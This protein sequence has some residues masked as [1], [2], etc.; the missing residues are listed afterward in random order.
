[1]MLARLAW[2]N[3]YRNKRRSLLT[4]AAVSF[5]TFLTVVFRGIAV[6]TWEYSLQ[7]T[8]TLFSGFLQVQ[9]HGYQDAPSLNKSFQYPEKVVLALESCPGVTGYAPRIMADG[10]ITYGANSSG[11]AI[12][13][14]DPLAER[15]VSRF[16]ERVRDGRMLQPDSPDEIV[17]GY[18]L[19][20]NLKA[21]VGD[22]LVVLA[23]GYDGVMGNNRYRVVG[24]LKMGVPEFDAMTVVMN[25]GAVQQLLAMDGR[26]NVVAV[27]S[28]D[29]SGLSGVQKQLARALAQRGLTNVE[30]LTWDEVMPELK[31]AMEVDL[32]NDSV[33]LVILIVIVTFGI[34]NTV[35]MSITERYR[36]FGITL[37]MG[38]QPAVLVRLVLFETALI[39][40]LGI[41]SGGL[42]GH[43][44]NWHFTAHPITLG[45]QLAQFYEDY[46]FLP[47]IVSTT[48]VSIPLTVMGGI[49][50]VSLIAGVYPAFRVSRLEPL[51][52]IRYT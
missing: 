48:R 27:G 7:N 2:R 52:G 24:T 10:L 41:L 30:V 5:A 11:A 43:I 14:I 17:V 1:M 49:L 3:L 29:F 31:Q 12:L 38:M 13:G 6:G 45:G 37:A 46:G 4:V 34:L 28:L 25:L 36:E 19:L 22:F 23:Q 8:V 39:A 32:V 16:H 9:R 21:K 15:K 50:V 51:K 44:A 33:L 18:K 47:Q 35:L 40:V 42:L 26:V 20:E